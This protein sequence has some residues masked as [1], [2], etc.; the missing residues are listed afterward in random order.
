MKRLVVVMLSVALVCAVTGSA[1][2]VSQAERD[3]HLFLNIQKEGVLKVGIGDGWPN[4]FQNATTGQ[5]DGVAVKFWQQIAKDLGVK[6]ELVGT[7]WEY[8]VANLLSGKIDAMAFMDRTFSR[9]LS[10]QF[11]QRINNTDIV[12]LYLKGNSKIPVKDTYSPGDIDKA[13]ITAGVMAGSSQETIA[14]KVFKNLKFVEFPGESQAE[15]A[16]QAGRIDIYLCWT[17]EEVNYLEQN[18]N[19]AEGHFNPPVGHAGGAVGLRRDVGY[20][21]LQVLDNAISNLKLDGSFK[22]WYA[23]YLPSGYDIDDLVAPPR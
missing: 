1:F 20:A 13:T 17:P 16:L 12:F 18:P 14:K 7:S 15:M 9:S 3:A 19:T 21:S 10:I 22:A 6:L 4:G 11:T 2:A 8:A 5:W 23:E